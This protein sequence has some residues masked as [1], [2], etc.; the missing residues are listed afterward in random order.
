M[1]SMR[2]VTRKPP[3]ILTLAMISAE[4]PSSL[5]VRWPEAPTASALD[6]D[7]EQSADHDHRG[8]GVGHRHQRRMQR[9]RH[10]PHHV[11]ADE[12]RQ[13]ED[14][15]AEHEFM[16]ALGLG[17]FLR[18]SRAEQRRFREHEA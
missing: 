10:A 4:R 6:R 8:N 2:C 12:D 3:K 11:I 9:R 7:G 13:H 17:R 15:E 1:L 5:A 18:V 14:R 16:P